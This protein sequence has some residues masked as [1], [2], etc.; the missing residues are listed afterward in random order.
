MSGLIV[1]LLMIHLAAARSL[2]RKQTMEVPAGSRNT[3]TESE[4][5][6]LQTELANLSI[7]S[8]LKDLYINLTYPNGEA[9]PASN[10]ENIKVNTIQS[11]KNQVKSELMHN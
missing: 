8:Y 3:N 6:Q 4:V 10:H 9:R 5:D 1:I 11:Y 7:P 2:P